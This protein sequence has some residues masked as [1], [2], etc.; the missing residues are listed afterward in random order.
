MDRTSAR[1]GGVALVLAGLM[2]IVGGFLHGPQP[3]TVEAYAELG[4]AWTASHV[5]IAAAGTLLV[6][7]AL[8]LARS[9]VA[10]A[11][12]G[13][14]LLGS[15][16][17]LLAGV[18]LL[19]V[20]TIETVGF[21]ALAGAASG[22]SAVAAEHAFLAASS[23]MTSMAMAAGYLL[24]VAVAAYGAAMLG[25]DAWPG[26]LAWIGVVVGAGVLGLHLAG[27]TVPAMPQLPMYLLNAW[28]VVAGVLFFGSAGP[29]ASEPER[30]TPEPRATATEEQHSRSMT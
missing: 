24:P 1:L 11:G 8:F 2:G 27:V 30:P 21:T 26:W 5:A 23:V 16:V 18:G 13:W 25:A 29:A 15:G 14:A 3:G 10:S 19:A 22:G 28:L 9:F 7:S 4:T 12:E 17:L 6:V 20:G